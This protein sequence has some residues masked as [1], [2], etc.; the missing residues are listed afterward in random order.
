M[1]NFLKISFIAAIAILLCGN[2]MSAQ[3]KLEE[4]FKA[5]SQLLSPEKLYLQTDRETYC[6][7]DTVWF[8]GY[9]VN[10]SLVSEFP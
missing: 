5:Y 9:L 8:K 4:R 6:V 3:N 1:K 2:T 10:N 7:G